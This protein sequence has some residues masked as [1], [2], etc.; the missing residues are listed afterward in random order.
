MNLYAF[1]SQV[2]AFVDA[3]LERLYVFARM[4]LRKL[5]RGDGK[6]PYEV[7][8]AIDM[9]SY[10][11]RK[12]SSGQIKLDRGQAELEP[13]KA[14]ASLPSTADEVE[15]LSAIITALNER[16]G[17]ELTEQDAVTVGQ[18][19]DGLATNE[20]LAS[21]VLVNTPD[22]AK[23][24]F[25]HVLNDLL[26][27]TISSNFKFY[28]RMSDDQDFASY[29]VQRLFEEYVRGSRSRAWSVRPVGPSDAAA[30][31]KSRVVSAGSE[32]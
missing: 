28:K 19:L 13:M 20:A 12:T 18:L 29:F 30:S 8:D 22:N 6:L 26:Q 32:S 24:T 27:D 31:S 9:A 2:L 16:F 15:P 4:L 25:Q 11:V 3:D 5:P 1:L 23:L 7:Q 17:T 10:G 21:S 14:K